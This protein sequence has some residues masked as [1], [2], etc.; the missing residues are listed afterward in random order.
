MCTDVCQCSNYRNI[1][2]YES[3]DETHSDDETSD[4]SDDE[5]IEN[6][7]FEMFLIFGFSI[8]EC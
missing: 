8:F 2:E 6:V 3:D 1:H 4:D 5:W 7:Y